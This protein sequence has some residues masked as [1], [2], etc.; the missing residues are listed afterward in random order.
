VAGL[1]IKALGVWIILL[2]LA[3]NN[4]FLRQKVL[5]GPLGES[6]AH[7]VSSVILSVAIFLLSYVFVKLQSEY[8]ISAFA[9]VGIL[10]LCMTIAFEFIFGHYVM[11]HSWQK[12]IED[13]NLAKG[14]IWVVVLIVTLAAPILCAIMLKK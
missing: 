2:I 1:I 10:W 8:G 5:L 11:K 9:I 6:R 13:Y 14:R 12:L 4:G 3:I 7:Q